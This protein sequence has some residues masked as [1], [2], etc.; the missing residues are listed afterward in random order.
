QTNNDLI[1]NQNKIIGSTIINQTFTSNIYF[2]NHPSTTN[3]SYDNLTSSNS[4]YDPTNL[5]LT[6]R[7]KTDIKT[8]QTAT[9]NH[10]IPS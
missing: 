6:N 1:K 4:N 3:K 8:L 7:I 10:F 2:H 5:A 9:P